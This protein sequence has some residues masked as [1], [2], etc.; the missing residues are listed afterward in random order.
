MGQV[1]Q[2]NG[3]QGA[4]YYPNQDNCA[5]WSRRDSARSHGG[6]YLEAVLMGRYEGLMK[7]AV[8]E[9]K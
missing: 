4:A 5:S 3:R 7:L 2:K 8:G 9:V 6:R 1:D